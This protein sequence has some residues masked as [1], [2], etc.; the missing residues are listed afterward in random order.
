[1][2]DDYSQY[3]QLQGKD[4]DELRRRVDVVNDHWEWLKR[5][6]NKYGNQ[7]KE[8]SKQTEEFENS[9]RIYLTTCNHWP[10]STEYQEHLGW[11]AKMVQYVNDL[12]KLSVELEQ[13]NEHKQELEVSTATVYSCVNVLL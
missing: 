6:V 5:I 7:H 4:H 3:S 8:I 1:M 10:S 2:K 13:L 12:P 9:M 11:S